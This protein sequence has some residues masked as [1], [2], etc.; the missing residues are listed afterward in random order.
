M[1]KGNPGTWVDLKDDS[2]NPGGNSQRATGD[3]IQEL[4]PSPQHQLELPELPQGRNLLGRRG[5]FYGWM[6]L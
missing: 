1:F 2:G 6:N 4:V 3:K 5:E